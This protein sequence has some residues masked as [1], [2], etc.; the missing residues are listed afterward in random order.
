MYTCKHVHTV[1]TITQCF[2]VQEVALFEL[3]TTPL[4]N[5]CKYF[6]FYVYNTEII[7]LKFFRLFSIQG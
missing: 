6:Q 5:V 3:G 7:G 1:N 2:K 4:P